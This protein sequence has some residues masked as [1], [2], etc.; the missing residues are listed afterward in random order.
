MQFTLLAIQYKVKF[1][2]PFEIDSFSKGR[3]PNPCD[4]ENYKDVIKKNR[5]LYMKV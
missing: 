1:N 3:Q 2:T 4:G 5:N